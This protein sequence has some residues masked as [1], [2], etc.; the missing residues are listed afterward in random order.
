[1][2]A[3]VEKETLEKA[4]RRIAAFVGVKSTIPVLQNVLVTAN[5]EDTT[6]E[7]LGTD[8]DNWA[9]SAAFAQAVTEPGEVLIN[10]KAL[11]T[12]LRARPKGLLCIE[13]VD[14]KPWI[15]QGEFQASLP[16]AARENYPNPPEAI[17]LDAEIKHGD[18][19]RG[20][21][22]LTVPAI[23]TEDGRYGLSCLKAIRESSNVTLV[24]TDGH[25]LAK[26]TVSEMVDDPNNLNFE[27][28][29][30][31]K[32]AKEILKTSGPLEFATKCTDENPYLMVRSR[33]VE[34]M[35]RRPDSQFPNW[36][37]ILLPSEDMK[38]WG[39]INAGHLL[40][41]LKSIESV[42]AGSEDSKKDRVVRFILRE[43]EDQC[44]LATTSL[45]G[46]TP[47]LQMPLKMEYYGNPLTVGFNA[48]YL[49]EHLALHD[50]TSMGIYFKDKSSQALFRWNHFGDTNGAVR[51]F[52][53]IVMPMR[54]TEENYTE[55]EGKHCSEV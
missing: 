37:L 8:L 14:G 50:T 29:L 5:G 35:W 52:E 49:R 1:M 22:K 7:L 47:R 39:T 31:A 43:G 33:E 41:T 10:F 13:V 45:N 42:I 48:R 55:A 21:L 36:K 12:I 18:Q 23:T 16:T 9:C 15:R 20:V 30:P 27:F 38:H 34:I 19:F 11:Q 25:R 53:L 51:G 17:D 26:G 24:A 4:L 28:L 54:L 3:F 32:V 44:K 2:K 40:Q 6:L 46:D